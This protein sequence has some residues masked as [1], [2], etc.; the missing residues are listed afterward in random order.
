METCVQWTGEGTS[1]ERPL[2]LTA[3]AIPPSGKPSSSP[4]A[5]GSSVFTVDRSNGTHLESLDGQ[6]SASNGWLAEFRGGRYHRNKVPM[7]GEWLM[8]EQVWRAPTPMSAAQRS[9]A[10]RS[11]PVDLPRAPA[12]SAREPLVVE[13][14][15]QVPGV[16]L[17]K[18]RGAVDG[19]TAP[20]LRRQLLVIT[21]LPQ[22]F[23]RLLLDLSG[24]SYLDRSGLDVLLHL[25][26]RWCNSAGSVELLAPSPSVVRLLHEADLDG[27][28]QMHAATTEP[29]DNESPR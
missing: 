26:E 22:G 5:P 7:G 16:V 4:S 29:A 17:I 15:R 13:I 14:D 2:P 1:A 8:A 10:T 20:V 12:G 27:E 28:S 23:T 24:V 3:K 9:A 6:N 18:L 19:G 21:P 25:Q 11:A